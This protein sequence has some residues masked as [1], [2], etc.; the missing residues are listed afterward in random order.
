MERTVVT[1]E[2]RMGSSRLPG[3]MLLPVCG[4]PVLQHVIERLQRVLL[5]DELV[6][7]T[8]SQP[9]DDLIEGLCNDLGVT[10]YRGSE[11]DVLSRLIEAVE[12]VGGDVIVQNTGDCPFIDPTV[13]D[14]AI[15]VFHSSDVDYVSNRLRRTYPA[16]QD[17]QV[18]RLDTLKRVAELTEDPED[19]EHGSYYIYTHPELFTMKNFEAEDIY[20]PEKRWLLD[21]PEDFDFMKAVYSRLY[22]TNP[23][24]NLYD[25]L[26]LLEEQPE[27]EGLNSMHPVSLDQ[28]PH[29][30]IL[31]GTLSER[32]HGELA[33]AL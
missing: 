11:N 28:Y 5:A 6:V 13:V 27:I 21:Y 3:K 26:S 15:E 31:P 30:E 24:F 17:P 14:R 9:G 12:Y 8:T 20:C 10:V 19:R 7:A 32:I 29:K 23:E 16:G 33:Q 18:F 4:K 22:L 1:I 25:I 2:A